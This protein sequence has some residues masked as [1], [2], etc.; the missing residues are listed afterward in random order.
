VIG[1]LHGA[2]SLG[3][4][5]CVEMLLRQKAKNDVPDKSGGLWHFLSP[6][7][8]AI[9]GGAIDIVHCLLRSVSNMKNPPIALNFAVCHSNSEIAVLFTKH[10][11][12]RD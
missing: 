8:I 7:H 12:N 4:I 2:V 9:Q 11:A 1:P 10:G 5:D 6:I 3:L